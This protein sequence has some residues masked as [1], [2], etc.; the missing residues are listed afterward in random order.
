NGSTIRSYGVEME[1]KYRFSS[2]WEALASLMVQQNEQDGR[3]D[4]NLTPNELLKTGVVY[5]PVHYASL[6][7][8]NQFIGAGAQETFFLVNP[9]P[10]SANIM[11]ANLHMDLNQW[12]QVS[13]YPESSFSLFVDNLLDEQYYTYGG[14][15][16]NTGPSYAGRAFFGTLSIRF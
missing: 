12:L 11:T 1:G 4:A 15:F 5:M 16:S 13:D 3:A 10:D 6:G 9:G 14:G 7:L 8:F 2:E